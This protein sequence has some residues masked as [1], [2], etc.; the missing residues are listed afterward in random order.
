MG[1]MIDCKTATK[2]ISQ[3]E[4]KRLS[5]IEQIKLYYHF[6]ICKVCSLF[7]KQNKVVVKSVA[8]MDKHEN[9]TLSEDEK[10]QMVAALEDSAA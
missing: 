3:K 1:L 10:I 8:L 2:M 4:E 6:F 5:W 7:F 9:S